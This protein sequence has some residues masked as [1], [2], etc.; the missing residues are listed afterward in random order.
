M[1]ATLSSSRNLPL[2]V[3]RGVA[4]LLVFGRHL[5]LPRP[6]GLVGA[7]AEAWF[8]VGWIGV[9][10]FFVLSGFLIGGLLVAELRK[11]GR[12][13]I[14][15][16][17][18][19][20]GF[21]IYPAYYVFIAYLVAMPMLKG[22]LAGQ[23]VATLGATQWQLYWPNLLFLQNYVGSNPAGHTWS[24]A[25]EEHF[26]LL[27]PFAL[28]WLA[29]AGRIQALVGAC[30]VAIAAI[31]LL[32][33][34]AVITVDPFSIRMAATHLRLDALLCGVALRALAEFR[35]PW[36]AG[37]RRWRPLLVAF[38][39]VCWAPNL[40]VDPS[41][42]WIRTVGLSATY[43]GSGAF[44]LAAYHTRAEDFGAWGKPV[45]QAARGLAWIG[46]YSYAIYLW[47]V[48]LMGFTERHVGRM[49]G[50]FE[51][52]PALEWAIATIIVCGAAVLG[53][54]LMTWLVERPA[55]AIRER[56]FPSRVGGG[57]SVPTT[58]GVAATPP[59]TPMARATPASRAGS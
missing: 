15:R 43:L 39:L 5:E 17:L 57:S 11:R 50:R 2:D 47:H 32:R 41:S 19:R 37:A 23:D 45:R 4:I 35:P 24:L 34:V 20:R 44:L 46:I 12:I 52:P 33:V 29:A 26:Y 3:L 58:E 22:W 27:L 55:L 31:F 28:A 1:L 48:T 53:G 25:V 10:L 54:A 59:E 42:P 51:G 56:W 14:V 8:R 36:F 9:D 49:V 13:D 6:E 30:V 7:V 21:K 40:I 18:I 16:F 38:G